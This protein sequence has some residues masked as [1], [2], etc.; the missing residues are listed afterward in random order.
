MMVAKQQGPDN[1]EPRTPEASTPTTFRQWCA[2]VL[3][4]AVDAR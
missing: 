3:A 1:S 4:P 2:E